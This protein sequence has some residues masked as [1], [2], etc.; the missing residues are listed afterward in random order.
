MN[1]TA[2]TVRATLLSC[3]AVALSSCTMFLPEPLVKRPTVEPGT[4]RNEVISALGPPRKTVACRPA[5]PGATFPDAPRSLRSTKIGQ[6]DQYSVS[7]LVQLP[8][9]NYRSEMNVY[10]VLFILTGGASELLCLP[11]VSGDLALRSAV[12]HRL[13]FWYDPRERLLDYRRR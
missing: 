13:E 3:V 7:G 12:R 11:L 2:Q 1:A 5:R 9:D 8:G 10:P 6:Y 4:H